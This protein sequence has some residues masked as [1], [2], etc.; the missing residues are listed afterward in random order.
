MIPDHTLCLKLVWSFQILSIKIAVKAGLKPPRTSKP[1]CTIVAGYFIIG[2]VLSGEWLVVLTT[3]RVSS[4]S[5]NLERDIYC[6]SNFIV[7]MMPLMPQNN[8]CGYGK[9]IGQSDHLP[10][11]EINYLPPPLKCFGVIFFQF[12]GLKKC[13]FSASACS[14]RSLE[15]F[16]ILEYV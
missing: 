6:L 10:N 5:C 13:L 3:K 2:P 7:I 14:L 11:S 8:L 16:L 4:I 15:S 1:Q 9:T 12:P